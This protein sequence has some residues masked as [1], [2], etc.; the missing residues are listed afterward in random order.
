MF[1]VLW[2]VYWQLLKSLFSY[3]NIFYLFISD[4]HP[5][6]EGVKQNFVVLVCCIF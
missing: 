1:N 3:G 2:L 6:F 4:F 5:L